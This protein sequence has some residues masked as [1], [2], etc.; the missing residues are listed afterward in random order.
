MNS[1]SSS[2]VNLSL[3]LKDKMAM[4]N[5]DVGGMLSRTVR[6]DAMDTQTK[7]GH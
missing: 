3:G 7:D 1:S 4:L 6:F 5:G 2:S